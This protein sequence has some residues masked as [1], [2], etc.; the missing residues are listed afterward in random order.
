M[1]PTLFQSV[2]P[3]KIV[4]VDSPVDTANST[5]ASV[6]VISQGPALGHGMMIDGTTLR[7]VKECAAKYP[8][9]LKVKM[10]H[11]GEVDDIVG[12][13][14]AFRISADGA[15]LLADLHILGTTPYRDYIFEIAEKIP[16]SFGLSIAFSGTFEERNGVR[17]A[18]CTEIYSADLVDSPAANRGL[19]SRG[20][21]EWQKARAGNAPISAP[22]PAT[23]QTQ[24]DNEILT[25]IGKLVDDKL[26]ALSASFDSKLAAIS[27][28]QANALS[29]IDEVAKLSTESADKAA[30]GAIKEFAKTLGQPAGAAAAPSAPPAAPVAKKFEALVKEHPAYAKSKAQAQAEVIKSNLAEYT[31]YRTRCM[32]GEIILF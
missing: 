24:M 16:E 23:N 17:Y 10:N 7:Q 2:A 28:A 15:K 13:L 5:I 19:F 22:A 18:R 32:T 8:G 11:D 26:A 21:D 29:K 30:L 3:E 20:F 12:Y 14:T 9:G 31:E 6:S 4:T 1:T 25:A 27:T